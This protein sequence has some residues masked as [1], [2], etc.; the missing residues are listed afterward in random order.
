MDQALALADELE[1]FIAKMRRAVKD[2]L[3]PDLMGIELIM[4]AE[5]AGVLDSQSAA[6]MRDFDEKIIDLINVDDFAFDAFSRPG[7]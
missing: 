5:A 1:P 3:V 7:H 4:A 2:K 6:R